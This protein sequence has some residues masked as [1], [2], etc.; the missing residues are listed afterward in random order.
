MALAKH[1]EEILERLHSN[2]NS[3]NYLIK[4]ENRWIITDDRWQQILAN[5]NNQIE[6]AEKICKELS[7]K[8]LL[9]LQNEID[10]LKK[11]NI[12]LR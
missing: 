1:Y 9:Q 8:D 2:V 6:K 11:E 3:I 7:N 10:N 5:L 4:P 12:E